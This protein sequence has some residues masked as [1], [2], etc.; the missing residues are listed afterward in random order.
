MT[1]DSRVLVDVPVGASRTL[2]LG[3]GKVEEYGG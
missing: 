3:G 2:G 1:T